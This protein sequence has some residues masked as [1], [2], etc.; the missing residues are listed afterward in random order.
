MRHGPSLDSLQT[1][2]CAINSQDDMVALA[3]QMLALPPIG[4][5]SLAEYAGQSN[6]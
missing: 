2:Y 6:Y 3:R 5:M 4:R 1:D